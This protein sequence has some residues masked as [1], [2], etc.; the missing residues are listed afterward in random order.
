MFNI[1]HIPFSAHQKQQEEVTVAY[2]FLKQT[3]KDLKNIHRYTA[4]FD[5][6]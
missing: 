1:Y 2:L 4:G 6:N 3:I 5:M